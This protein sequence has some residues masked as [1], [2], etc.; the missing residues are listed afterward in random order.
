M[1]RH[2]V[3]RVA[4]GDRPVETDDVCDAVD[5][6]CQMTTTPMYRVPRLRPGASLTIRYQTIAVESVAP[7]SVVT[8]RY[9]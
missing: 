8:S 5:G 1:F 6:V 9:G 3:V 2:E 7:T 4:E